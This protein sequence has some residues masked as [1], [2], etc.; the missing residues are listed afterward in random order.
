[1]TTTS[2]LGKCRLAAALMFA[3]AYGSAV[4]DPAT[5]IHTTS[6]NPSTPSAG[7]SAPVAANA[8]SLSAAPPTTHTDPVPVTDSDFYA[9]ESQLQREAALL[10]LQ[11]QIADLKKKISQ[12]ADGAESLPPPPAPV[13]VA[14]P[15]VMTPQSGVPGIKPS[16]AIASLT[17]PLPDDGA[18]EAPLRVSSVLGIAGDYSAEI[19]DHGVS[20]TVYEGGTLSDGWHVSKIAP[21]TVVLTRGRARRILHV[22]H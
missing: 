19:I 18:Q 8:A 2:H 7:S 13:I 10:K 4:A 17:L 14:P 21:S 16:G 9:R 11:S 15:A 6:A 20:N 5:D 3:L 12:S 22:S 1:M